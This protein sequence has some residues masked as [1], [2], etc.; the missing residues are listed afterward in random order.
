LAGLK[1]VR[2]RKDGKIAEA[3]CSVDERKKMTREGSPIKAFIAERLIID[4]TSTMLKDACH[5]DYLKWCAANDEVPRSK[6]WFIRDLETATGG[7]V[8][9]FKDQRGGAVVHMIR[10]ARL[11]KSKGDQDEIPF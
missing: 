1:R 11:C 2:A 6:S 7:A 5:A 8:V 3:K 9:A 10:G 4:P